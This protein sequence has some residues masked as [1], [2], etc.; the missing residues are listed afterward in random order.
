MKIKLS[1][2]S[3]FLLPYERQ[4]KNADPYDSTKHF[5]S[6]DDRSYTKQQKRWMLWFLNQINQVISENYL[7]HKKY[8]Y[9]FFKKWFPRAKYFGEWFDTAKCILVKVDLKN[10]LVVSCCILCRQA[11]C[12]LTLEISRTDA[13]DCI[14]WQCLL[15]FVN[16]CRLFH[17]Y[18]FYQLLYV[19]PTPPTYNVG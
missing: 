6:R 9:L 12:R 14:A 1:V 19:Y 5:S 18:N 13:C 10:R 7:T 17:I 11:S 4:K 8:F 15:C 3:I 2:I 16:L